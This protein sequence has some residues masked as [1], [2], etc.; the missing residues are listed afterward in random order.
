MRSPLSLLFSKLNSPRA[1]SLSSQ[2]RCSRTLTIFIALRRTLSGRSLSFLN[3]GAQKLQAVLMSWATSCTDACCP[4]SPGAGLYICSCWTSSG[5]SPPNPAVCPGLAEQ[6]H[7]LLVYQPLLPALHCLRVDSIP[8]SR[9]VMKMLNKTRFSTYPWGTPLVTGLMENFLAFPTPLL[10]VQA[11]LESFA[12]PEIPPWSLSWVQQ[13]VCWR[14]LLS[15]LEAPSGVSPTDGFL[16]QK[17]EVLWISF[18]DRNKKR[19]LCLIKTRVSLNF[20]GNTRR[21]EAKHVNKSTLKSKSEEFRADEERARN[22]CPL[23]ESNWV[24]RGDQ[25]TWI[26]SDKVGETLWCVWRKHFT[27]CLEVYHDRSI[28]EELVSEFWFLA[29][30]QQW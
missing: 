24:Q 11:H 12:K 14:H 27:L 9:P 29:P 20:Y 13:K 18:W 19:I 2:W 25:T 10:P 21:L 3:W 1:L 30:T 17:L 8:S 28:L 16:Y 7:G 22:F 23:S 15:Y 26:S 6:Q 5:S 4:S